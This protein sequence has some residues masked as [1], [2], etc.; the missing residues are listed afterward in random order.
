MLTTSTEDDFVVEVRF[1]IV[2][3]ADGY[4]ESRNAEALL[5]K[6]IDPECKTCIV[7]SVPLFVKNLAYG[8]HNQYHFRLRRLLA[9]QRSRRSW[10]V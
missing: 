8:G 3:D 5:C 6:A 7:M 2:K 1:D 10:R 4:P 9:L